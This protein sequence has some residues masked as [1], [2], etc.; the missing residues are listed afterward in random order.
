MDPLLVLGKPHTRVQHCDPVFHGK[1]VS[2]HP[3]HLYLPGL[4]Q[5]PP[6]LFHL[7][8]SKT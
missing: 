5:T 2:L 4:Q 6:A 1:S 7:R 3:T 8:I